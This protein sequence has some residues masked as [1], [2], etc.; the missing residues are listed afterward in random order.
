MRRMD[1]RVTQWQAW[2][3]KRMQGRQRTR[4][5]D[6]IGS[7]VGVTYNRQ[8][9]DRDKKRRL[10]EAFSCSGLNEVN[11]NGDG[12]QEREQHPTQTAIGKQN[13]R[14]LMYECYY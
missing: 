6:E 10:E 2:D 11:N 9:A 14:F 3:G 5:R 1:N 7:I 4:Q 12:D 13:C 8:A